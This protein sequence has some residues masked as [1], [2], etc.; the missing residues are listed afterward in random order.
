MRKHEGEGK[1]AYQYEMTELRFRAAQPEGSQVAVD[2]SAVFHKGDKT[3]QVK[4]FYAGNGEYRVRFLPEEAG[5]YQYEVSGL[6]TAEGEITADPDREGRHGPVRAK[7]IHLYHADGTPWVG[8]GTTIYAMLH[9]DEALIDETMDTLRHSPFTKVRLCLFPKHYNYN[10]NDPAHFAF[11][12]NDQGEWDMERPDFAFWDAFEKRL[13]EMDT[14]G[15]QA[16][17]ILFHPYDRWG[18]STLTQTQNLAYL[19]YLTRRFAAYPNVWW[20]LA[21]EYDLCSAKTMEDWYGIEEFVS[22][23]DPFHHL[24]SNHN[25][26]QPY[27]PSRENITHMSWQTKQ[28]SRIPEMQR[29]YGKPILI[30]ECCYEGNLPE[31]WGSI[32][33][34][35]MTARFWRAATL[36]GYCTHGETFYPDEK[37]I[38]WWAKGG[39]LAGESPARIAFLRSVLKSLPGPLSPRLIG[40]QKAASLSEEQIEQLL[41]APVTAR[42]I[43]DIG[44]ARMGAIE[45]SR[46]AAQETGVCGVCGPEDAPGAIL[47]YLDFNCCCQTDLELPENG[48]YK[49]EVLDTWNMTRETVLTG[50]H[51]RQVISLPGREWMA[52]L[53]TKET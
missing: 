40:L 28:I 11:L 22:K 27:D 3:W 25:C 8:L 38:V 44:I 26:F 15:I 33:G 18:H 53:A 24:L 47:K 1:M 36:G 50:V 29:R 46:F 31:T 37:E 48:S 41:N 13:A 39:K 17:L 43:F 20:S 30:D 19:D 12:R 10:H 52:A 35:E 21:N 4:G 2:L 23:N 14:M 16:D 32:S 5:V 42:N 51:G 34:K 6:I 49:V 45:I 7:G 9:Q